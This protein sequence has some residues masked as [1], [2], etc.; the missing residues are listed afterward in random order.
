[1]KNSNVLLT[2]AAPVGAADTSTKPAHL[3]FYQKVLNMTLGIHHGF[4]GG[5]SN[6]PSTRK[7][8]DALA[9]SPFRRGY[10][11]PRVMTPVMAVATGTGSSTPVVVVTTT[12]PH[13]NS[14]SAAKAASIF[15]SFRRRSLRRSFRRTK[16]FLVKNSTPTSTPVVSTPVAGREE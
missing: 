7:A 13:S 9:S 16:S 10:Q 6:S 12:P 14:S 3:P 5:G 15:R 4:N 2:S 8:E 1:M 11:R